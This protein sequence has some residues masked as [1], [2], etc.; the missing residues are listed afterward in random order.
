M[1]GH[2]YRH[3]ERDG[4]HHGARWIA[5]SA[6]VAATVTGLGVPTAAPA[7][8]AVDPGAYQGV[9]AG[10]TPVRARAGG[11]LTCPPGR[12]A[13][14][15]GA[16]LPS[17]DG[18]LTA[19]TPTEDGD[20]WY[21]AARL[22]SSLGPELTAFGMC[23]PAAHVAAASTIVVSDHRDRKDFHVQRSCPAGQLALA[24]GGFLHRPGEGPDPADD[25]AG[26]ALISRPTADGTGWEHA[27]SYT[28]SY[29]DRDHTF[30]LR[31]LPA[32]ELPGAVGVTTSTA[33]PARRTRGLVPV[34]AAGFARC[35]DGTSVYAGG[36]V[37]TKANGELIGGV[38]TSAPAFDGSGWH[39]TG[40]GPGGGTLTVTA[41]CV[42]RPRLIGGDPGGILQQ[43]R[44]VTLP[45]QAP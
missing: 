27:V 5:I 11:H 35:P 14:A 15:G 17:S 23:V 22:N 6:L 18:S 43:H 34:P 42:P 19:L 21:V 12:K 31:C 4:S 29:G 30:V 7:A 44:D 25:D 33:I 9:Y 16:Y 45:A 36:G 10:F 39:M 28:G 13:V 38:S 37:F 24:G 40:I 41:R 32:S 3:R 2:I 8:A 20:G 1:G 26:F